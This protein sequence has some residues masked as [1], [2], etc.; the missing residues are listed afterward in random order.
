[1]KRRHSRRDVECHRTPRLKCDRCRGWRRR[2]GLDQ[3]LAVRLV[4]TDAARQRH[5]RSSPRLPYDRGNNMDWLT[6]DSIH[7]WS[8][9]FALQA[10][11][12]T[13]VVSDRRLSSLLLFACLLGDG[14]GPTGFST[15]LVSGLLCGQGGGAASSSPPASRF[16]AH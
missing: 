3:C 9:S 7:G 5:G 10:E 6:Q 11:M 4:T 15:S 2:E 14:H 8:V 1:M 13:S 12:L 16:P